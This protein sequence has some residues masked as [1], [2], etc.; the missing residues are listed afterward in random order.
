MSLAEIKSSIDQM[1]EEERFYAAAYLQHLAQERDPSY[2][3][4]LTE[5]VDRMS[6][7]AKVSFEQVRQA[8]NDLESQGR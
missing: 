3:A 5:R 6:S 7:G 1:T 8:H 2:Q 4:A